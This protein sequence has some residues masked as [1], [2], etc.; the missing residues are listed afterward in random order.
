M[1]S[2]EF[3]AVTDHRF[4]E[5][6]QKKLP[7]IEQ[8]FGLS[9][10][11][12]GDKIIYDG[13]P[14]RRSAFKKFI[15]QVFEINREKGTITENELDI[16]LNL[17]Q[18]SPAPSL[19]RE[20]L[21]DPVFLTINGI[22]VHPKTVNQKKYLKSIREH[23]LVF[24]IGPA[25]TGKTFLAIAMALHYLFRKKVDRI[26]LTRPVVEAGENLGFLPGD[27]KQKVNPYFRPLYDA[28]YSLIGIE[29]SQELIEREI[30]EIAPLAYMRGRT[31]D[32]SFIILDEG[33]N[34]LNSQMKMF[35]T[36]FGQNSKVIVT[37]D[38]SQIDLPREK[39]SGV[40]LARNIL[41]NIREI[42]FISLTSRDVI[43]HS[44]VQKIIDSYQMFQKKKGS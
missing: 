21:E 11:L 44:L 4:A 30:I 3:P 10:S 40:I 43:R 25:G 8:T 39:K 35:L 38:T 7:K 33:Q 20:I 16:S 19:R 34:T 22:E 27:I 28:L 32:H 23:D 18:Q 24:A 37:A 13:P 5:V 15:R 42:A 17:F 41:R 14:V 9:V 36:R 2:L 29:K 26:V 1:D 12:R 31:I 6:L